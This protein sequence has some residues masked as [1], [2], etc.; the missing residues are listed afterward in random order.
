MATFPPLTRVIRAAAVA[1]FAASLS[2]HAAAEVKEVRIAQQFGIGYL[3]LV[4]VK[5]QG[6]LEKHAERLGLGP[7]KVQWSTFTGGSS[8]ND[9]LIS[10]NLDF[11]SGGVT[12][13]LTLWSRTQGSSQVK[14]ASVMSQMPMYLHRM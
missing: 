1:L 4:I 6:L 14:I 13:F 8:M 9:A 12:P 10:G 5:A 3:P 2:I 7:V 11:A